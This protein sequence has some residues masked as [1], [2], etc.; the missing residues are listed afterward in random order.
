MSTQA[1]YSKVNPQKLL[2]LI[3]K[4]NQKSIDKIERNEITPATTFLQGMC[5]EIPEE[6]YFKAHKHNMQERATTQTH[7][8]FLIFKGAIELSIFD[9]DNTLLEKATLREGDCSIILSGGHS[10]KTLEPTILYEF[11]NGPYYGPEKDKT[12]IE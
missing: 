1:I 6:T 4:F 9:T 3:F 2:H 10:F 5:F 8:A 12:Y 7:E 11:K